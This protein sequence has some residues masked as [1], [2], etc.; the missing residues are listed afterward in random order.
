MNGNSCD[1]MWNCASS[2]IVPTSTMALQTGPILN[3]TFPNSIHKKSPSNPMGNGVTPS[4]LSENTI[5]EASED[6]FCLPMSTK[7][8]DRSEE[9]INVISLPPSSPFSQLFPSQ[10]LEENGVEVDEEPISVPSSSGTSLIYKNTSTKVE[11]SIATS[12]A[13]I[14]NCPTATTVQT[15]RK[16]GVKQHFCSQCNAGFTRQ[17][18]LNKHVREKHTFAQMK[19][20]PFPNCQFQTINPNTMITHK[21]NHQH[22][23]IGKPLYFCKSC[24][25]RYVTRRS[26]LQ[27]LTR[28]HAS[29]ASLIGMGQ[30]DPIESDLPTSL[31]IDHTEIENPEAQ[32]PDAQSVRQKVTRSMT[33]TNSSTSSNAP[34]RLDHCSPPASNSKRSS[35][36]QD[37]PTSSSQPKLYECDRCPFAAKTFQSLFTHKAKK[38]HQSKKDSS[39]GGVNCIYCRRRFRSG[40]SLQAHI[41]ADHIGKKNKNASGKSKK[42]KLFF[43]CNKCDFVTSTKRVFTAHNRMHE[44]GEGEYEDEVDSETPSGRR[45]PVSTQTS[46][47]TIQ[48]CKGT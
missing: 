13:V 32:L 19:H 2:D 44:E 22:R 12:D 37:S 26:L 11:T 28:Q 3:G 23:F 24:K 33:R 40:E 16:C 9:P 29:D 1:P 15:S 42:S 8:R 25:V 46:T 5:S 6:G 48:V 36:K 41:K 4:Q 38:H 18:T 30:S 27:H 7:A 34:A 21:R 20:C 14:A 31:H 35:L 17:N 10:I 45:S 39:H 43:S 47:S